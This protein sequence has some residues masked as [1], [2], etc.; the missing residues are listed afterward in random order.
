MQ[1]KTILAILPLSLVRFKTH[2]SLLSLSFSD[3]YFSLFLT[4]FL[5][6]SLFLSFTV[7]NKNICLT[8]GFYISFI[9]YFGNLSTR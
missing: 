2:I 7:Y 1:V 5:T 8:K 4:L 6:H 3:R 9:N